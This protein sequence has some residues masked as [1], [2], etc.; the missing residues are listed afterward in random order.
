M[1][2]TFAFFIAIAF[3]LAGCA[4]VKT[5]SVYKR[6]ARGMSQPTIAQRTGVAAATCEAQYAGDRQNYL[7]AIQTLLA[8]GFSLPD[9]TKA[10]LETFRAE[11]NA[12]YNTVVMR[13]KTHINCLE[14]KFYDE[15]ACYMSATDLKDAERRFA[16]L[17]ERLREI[18]RR[19]EA[20]IARAKKRGP[21]I[22]LNQKNEQNQS[23]DQS[24]T[25]DT[26]NGDVIED[27][28]VLKIC[29]SAEGLLK[30]PCRQPCGKRC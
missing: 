26:H 23:S 22:T 1:H 7:S 12:A 15:A 30:R 10:P 28:D 6:S 25:T 20:D 9:A 17:S 4:D 3:I 16:D 14:V 29:G 27:M 24:Q 2:R 18:E 21:D 8:Q 5:K 11:V 19:S 13:C